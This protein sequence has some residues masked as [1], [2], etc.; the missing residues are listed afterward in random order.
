MNV[1]DTV[2]ST[3]DPQETL[4]NISDT[5]HSTP[6]PQET[7][8]NISDTG[9]NTPNPQ[10]TLMTISDTV[11]S[12][13]DP[14]ETLANISDTVHSTLDPPETLANRDTVKRTNIEVTSVNISTKAFRPHST[15][16][17][18]QYAFIDEEIERQR[19]WKLQSS[20]Q[21]IEH[22]LKDSNDSSRTREINRRWKAIY[23]ASLSD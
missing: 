19:K 13:P 9:H 4:V 21:I 23:R 3:P 6:D 2:H 8:V 22:Q 12:T 7:L 14:Q 15:I 17:N 10:E 11:H 1:S 20:Q 18:Q 5:G 16:A